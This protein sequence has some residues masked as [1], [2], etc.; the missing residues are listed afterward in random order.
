[1]KETIAIVWSWEDIRDRAQN[2]DITLDKEDCCEILE[3]IEE[4]H[5]AIMGINWEVIDWFIEQ[6]IEIERGE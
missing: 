5:D 6:Y 4:N 2:N 1:M 3:Y